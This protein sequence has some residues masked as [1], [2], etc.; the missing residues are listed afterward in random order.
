MPVGATEKPGELGLVEVLPD[1]NLLGDFVKICRP[2]N[3]LKISLRN[4]HLPSFLFA[5]SPP[6][7]PR[8]AV[9]FIPCPLPTGA[10]VYV[11]N[12]LIFGVAPHMQKLFGSKPNWRSLSVSSS[13]SRTPTEYSK[14]IPSGPDRKS[15][16]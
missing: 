16:V 4:R 11:D 8:D 2:D 6:A 15:V 7:S 5:I 3:V 14:T 10:Q 12:S 1:E 13:T 9:T